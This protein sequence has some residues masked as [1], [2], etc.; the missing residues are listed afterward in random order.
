MTK[1]TGTE[2]PSNVSHSFKAFNKIHKAWRGLTTKLKNRFGVCVLGLRR[3][4][5]LSPLCVTKI[6]PKKICRPNKS[7]QEFL[8]TN[9]APLALWKY[10]NKNLKCQAMIWFF[11]IKDQLNEGIIAQKLQSNDVWQNLT[12]P[13]LYKNVEIVEIN[14]FRLRI[15]IWNFRWFSGLVHDAW[16]FFLSKKTLG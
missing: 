6:H 1:E 2:L 11:R 16:T 10:S 4:V 15:I 7:N 5:L 14:W 12:R 9:C 8:W 13:K 3:K